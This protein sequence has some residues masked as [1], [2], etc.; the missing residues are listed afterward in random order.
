M[1]ASGVSPVDNAESGLVRVPGFPRLSREIVSAKDGQKRLELFRIPEGIGFLRPQLSAGV[2]SLYQQLMPVRLLGQQTNQVFVIDC[3]STAI[4]GLG[5]KG[6][7]AVKVWDR[8]RED[9]VG[10]SLDGKPR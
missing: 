10:A 7:C 5:R 1:R 2:Q 8:G 9:P 4:I 3:H 6:R